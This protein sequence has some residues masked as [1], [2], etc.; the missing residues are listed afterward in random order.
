MSIRHAVIR[1]LL[2]LSGN[3]AYS[4]YAELLRTERLPAEDVARRQDALLAALLRHC[5]QNVPYYR[6][7]LEEAGV[8]YRGQVQLEYFQDLPVLTR[9]ILHN[10]YDR[11]QARDGEARRRDPYEEQSGGSTGEPVRFVLDKDMFSWVVATKFYFC[12]LAGKAPGDREMRLWGSERDLLE[13]QE[14]PAIRLRNWLY[15]RREINAFRMTPERMRAYITEI[16]SWRPALIEAY[17]APIYE[18]AR[19]AESNGLAIVSP[20]AII[21]SAGT[22]HPFMRDTLARVLGTRVF[23]RYGTREVGDIACDCSLAKGLHLV[24]PVHRTEILGADS[25]PVSHGQSGKVSVTTLR[26]YSMP[27]VRYDIGDYAVRSETPCDCGR[28]FPVLQHVEGRETEVFRTRDGS[29][30]SGEFF[31]HFLGVVLNEGYARKVQAIQEDFDHVRIRIVVSDEQRFHQKQQDIV[32]AI[33][34]TMGPDCRVSFDC[35]DDIPPLPSGKYLY[36]V[37][38]VLSKDSGHGNG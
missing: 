17:A 6:G 25:R 8:I 26:N 20:E 36:T 33:R 27:L 35:V 37:S 30:V 9:H 11:L 18:L 15:N 21:T 12:S 4:H 19:F 14:S 31:I 7:L 1:L 34:K 10:E 23:N 16:N 22:L 3:R 5:H 13:G 28:S 24:T 29:I 32:A 2:L 38:K